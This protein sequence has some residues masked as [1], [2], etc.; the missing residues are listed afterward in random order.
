MTYI[1]QNQNISCEGEIIRHL[2]WGSCDINLK[3]EET[4]CTSKL[5]NICIVL[6]NGNG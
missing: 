6:C 4:K 3:I 1:E 2:L 5:G